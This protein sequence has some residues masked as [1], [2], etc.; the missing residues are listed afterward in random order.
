LRPGDGGAND[1]LAQ[2]ALVRENWQKIV[3]K[4]LRGGARID[5]PS[6]DHEPDVSVAEIYAKNGGSTQDIEAQLRR[7]LEVEP[8]NRKARGAA[9][10]SA[11]ARGALARRG[12]APRHRIETSSSARSA[13]R[14]CCPRRGRSRK[15]AGAT[16]P[17]DD[18]EVLG[19]TR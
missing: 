18:E 15:A 8:R 14:C 6:A 4:Y 10:P 5:G 11:A 3:K 16:L 1:A 9:G 7:A 12:D 13:W 17:G 2:I 19:S